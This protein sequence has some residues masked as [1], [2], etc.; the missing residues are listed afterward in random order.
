MTLLTKHIYKVLQRL[1]T[2]KGNNTLPKHKTGT[3]NFE[4]VNKSNTA[5]GIIGRDK[6]LGAHI[7]KCKNVQIHV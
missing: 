7:A 5:D 1:P 2:P 3:I 4:R 6:R